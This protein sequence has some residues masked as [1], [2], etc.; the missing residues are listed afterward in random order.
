MAKSKVYDWSRDKQLRKELSGPKGHGKLLP[1]K[2][3]RRR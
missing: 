1:L 2:L 3:P